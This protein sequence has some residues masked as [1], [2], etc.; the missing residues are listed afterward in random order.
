MYTL[1]YSKWVTNK[2]LADSTENSAECYVPAWMGGGFRGEWIHVY[3]RL[4]PFAVHLKLPQHCESA[5]SQNKTKSLKLEKKKK[6]P[7]SRGLLE[8]YSE[9][10]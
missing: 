3:V 7:S 2:D 6:R 1:R 4:S 9:I 5:I 10:M 8:G